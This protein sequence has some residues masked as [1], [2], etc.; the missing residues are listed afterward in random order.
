VIEALH[1]AFPE[2]ILSSDTY[3][4]RVANAAVQA[5]ATMIN[6]ISGGQLDP[7]MLTVAGKLNVPYVC[8]HMKGEPSTMQEKP[9]YENITLEVLDYFIRRV[10][11]CRAAGIKDIIIDPG[12]GFGKTIAHNFELFRHMNSL[13]ILGLPILIGWSR[14]ST[15]WKTLGVT[16]A[17]SLNG[18][19]VMNTIAIERGA[20]ILRVHDVREAMEVVRLMEAMKA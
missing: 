16:A 2:V 1:Q 5:G 19:T 12:F 10:K 18:T 20:S 8:M 9:E 14:K 3:H 17:E 6:D 13:H 11:D 7:D 15:I 4:A